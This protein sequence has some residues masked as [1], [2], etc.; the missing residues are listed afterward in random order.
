[1]KKTLIMGV[2]NITPDSFSDGGKYFSTEKAVE[3]AIQLAHDGADIIDLGAE[4]SRPGANPLDQNEEWSRLEPVISELVKRKPFLKVSVDSYKPQIMLRSAQIGCHFINDINGTT[5]L[6][7]LKELAT[8]KHLSYIA[9]H[10]AGDPKSMQLKP[11]DAKDALDALETF[12]EQTLTKLT[13][14]GFQDEQIYLDPGIGFGKTDETNAQIIAKCTDWSK[15][16]NLVVGVSRKSFIGRTLNIENPWERD[17][18]SKMLEFALACM[19]V[20]IIR[21]HEVAKL[22]HLIRLIEK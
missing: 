1:M 2:V 9:M 10:K 3:R 8:F 11:M 5:D 19:G 20:H 16:Y 12:F 13:K 22:N 17:A 14:A 6:G 21:T 15:E 18:P 4:S 7:V